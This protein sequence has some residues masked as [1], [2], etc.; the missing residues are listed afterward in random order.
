MDNIVGRLMKKD[1]NFFVGLIIQ[2]YVQHN[3]SIYHIA[4]ME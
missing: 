2:Y 4:Y 3:S 1:K